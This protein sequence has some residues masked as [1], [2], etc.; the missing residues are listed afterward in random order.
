MKHWN[1]LALMSK[2]SKSLKSIL[3][4]R[5]LCSSFPLPPFMIHPIQKGNRRLNWK[6]ISACPRMAGLSPCCSQCSAVSRKLLTGSV[7]RFGNCPVFMRLVQFFLSFL[8][9]FIG[10]FGTQSPSKSVQNMPFSW[11][12]FDAHHLTMCWFFFF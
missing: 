2:I 1:N 5:K 8:Q 6:C 3:R 9:L 7:S 10:L 4:P 12:E 11:T